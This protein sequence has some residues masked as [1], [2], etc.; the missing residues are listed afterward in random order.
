M[1]H[2][3]KFSPVFFKKKTIMQRKEIF[4]R[5]LQRNFHMQRKACK[6]KHAKQRKA[7]HMRKSKEKHFTCKE[8]FFAKKFSHAKK[9]MQRNFHPFLKKK[10]RFLKKKTMRKTRFLKKK[11]IHL[12]F[13]FFS[14]NLLFKRSKILFFFY[15]KQKNPILNCFYSMMQYHYFQNYTI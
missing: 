10:T 8:K 4:T 11:T 5:F 13:L 15:R 2:A 1:K 6:A 3:K 9:S 7:F 12:F 14:K